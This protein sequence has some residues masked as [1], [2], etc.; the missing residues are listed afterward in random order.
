MAARNSLPAKNSDRSGLVCTVCDTQV[1]ADRVRKH[2]KECKPESPGMGS[3]TKW[4]RDYGRDVK[5]SLHIRPGGYVE[6]H[7]PAGLLGYGWLRDAR[8]GA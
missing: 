7:D 1:R 5:A 3:A 2:R 8:G 6:V 4:E